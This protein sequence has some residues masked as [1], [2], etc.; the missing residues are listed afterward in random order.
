VR[1]LPENIHAVYDGHGHS[2]PVAF[3]FPKTVMGNPVAVFFYFPIILTFCSRRKQ[4]RYMSIGNPLFN[5]ELIQL[6]AVDHEKDPEIVSRWTHNA[7]FMRMMY[8]DPMKPL[9]VWQVKKKLEELEKSMEDD[10]NLFHFHIRT[11]SDNRLVGFAE[12]SWIS[13]TNGSGYI[14]LGI[15]DPEDHHKGYGR[16]T[17]C[18]LLRYAFEELNLYRLSA[19]IPEY[20]LP[21]QSLFKSAIFV[22]EVRQ[23]QALERDGRR[24]DSLDFGLL[25]EVWKDGLK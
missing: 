20:N 15:G 3:F 21:A 19:I 6:G 18:L 11:R 22:E 4:R 7:G 9:S 2:L 14:R 5:G 1:L 12:L 17:L 25:A 16:Q 8:M 24:W 10:K 13:W 23:R